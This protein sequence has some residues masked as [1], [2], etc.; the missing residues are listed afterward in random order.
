[1][2]SQVVADASVVLKWQLEDEEAGCRSS[3]IERRLLVPWKELF[4]P[5][6]L[7]PFL[8]QQ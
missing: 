6:S 1:M 3:D 4:D 7:D 2:P 8:F 5:F